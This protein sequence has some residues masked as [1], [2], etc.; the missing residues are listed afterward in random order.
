MRNTDLAIGISGI[1]GQ[2][3]VTAGKIIA[4]SFLSSELSVFKYD[5]YSAEIRGG[6]KSSTFIRITEQPVGVPPQW[7]D[8]CIF[9]DSKFIRDEIQH[10]NEHT[11]IF[12]DS[13]LK[14]PEL[15]TTH[16]TPVP[17]SEILRES[18]AGS[19]NKNMVMI[20]IIQFL[21]RI[22]ENA[23][24][25]AIKRL[26]VR[27]GDVFVQR[28]I[29]TQQTILNKLNAYLK[30][31]CWDL[32]SYFHE[33]VD[34]TYEIMDGNTAIATGALDADIQLYAGYPIT[35]ASPVMEWMAR[36]LPPR[37]KMYL[38]MEDEIASLAAVIGSWY[39]G[40]RAMTATSGPGLS[41][42]VEM[43]NFSFM[44][45]IPCVIVDVQRAGPATGMP[46]KTEQSDLWLSVFGGAG[47]FARV[48]LAPTTIP[49]SYE[50]TKL[51]FHLA[52]KYQIPVIVLSDLFLSY[53]QEKIRLN[54]SVSQNGTS[55][56]RPDSIHSEYHRFQLTDSGVSPW[57]IPGEAPVP[58]TVSGLEHDEKGNSNYSSENHLAMTQKRL[59]KMEMVKADLPEPAF[60][61]N[62][63]APFGI[64]AWGSMVPVVK[65]LVKQSPEYK[66]LYSMAIYPFH[67]Q[68]FQQFVDSCQQVVIPEM[69]QTGQY[70]SL[71]KMFVDFDPVR[72]SFPSVH[73]VTLEILKTQL[74][75]KIHEYRYASK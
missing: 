54:R 33:Q 35:P 34:E 18:G 48:V 26:F 32:G 14:L 72:L 20:S 53:H 49:E 45:E 47:D 6:G 56:I 61:G 41:L 5:D 15:P 24:Q 43:L 70:A 31:R 29:D 36:E 39:G 60:F 46:T 9:S 63:E 38:Q 2:G 27:K 28:L 21:Y 42:M 17:F 30:E 37:G 13:A 67:Y 74:E 12:Y 25:S 16:I 19:K 64:I 58:Y 69:N 22:P 8:V 44:A 71:L 66:M 75:E 3:I 10:I 62:P 55:R 11:R 68:K 59:K 50:A 1:A 4:H 73:P 52:E 65:E 51:A 57:A 23:I 40:N 7:M